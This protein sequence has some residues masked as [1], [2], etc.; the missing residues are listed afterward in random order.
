MNVDHQINLT[1]GEIAALWTVYM[2]DSMFMQVLEF[3]LKDLKDD[4]IKPIV[5]HAY[6]LSCNHIEQLTT[7]FQKE[8]YAIPN[9]FAKEDVNLNAPW[10]FT[11]VF[12]LTYVN[13]MTKIGAITYGGLLSMSTR[14]DIREYFTGRLQETTELYNRCTDIALEKGVNARHPYIS[15]PK[16]IDYVDSKN[17][18]SGLNPFQEKRSLNAIEISYLYMNTMTNSIGN[19]LCLAFAQ[20]S[21]LKEV[22]EYLLRCS[23]VAKKHLKIFSELLKNEDIEVPEVP[24]LSISDSVTWTFSDKLIMFHISLMMQAGIGNYGTASAASQRSDLMLNYER[25]SLEVAKLAK[26]G[27]DIMIQH[28][29]LEQPPGIQSRRQLA[30]K[31]EKS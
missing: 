17:Y 11:D 30:R 31:K 12:C 27:A 4:D 18:L 2:N 19:K 26:S 24:D 23:D 21:P 7:I 28:N 22:Q 10:L 20:T 9:G 1:S 8:D 15:V 29:W 5:Q 13:Y 16:D 3:M 25:L 6:E 14:K